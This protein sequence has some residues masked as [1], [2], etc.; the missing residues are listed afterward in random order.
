MC[1]K[2]NV[3][4]NP[5]TNETVNLNRDTPNALIVGA[6]GAGKSVLLRNLIHG[7]VTE[8]SPE[9]L[10]I[11][12]VDCR[13]GGF[14]EFA[15]GEGNCIVPHVSYLFSSKCSHVM[16]SALFMFE[17]ELR[18][19][20]QVLKDASVGTIDEYNAEFSESSGPMPELVLI[21]D[22]VGMALPEYMQPEME[23]FLSYV[24]QVQRTVGAHIIFCNQGPCKCNWATIMNMCDNRIVLRTTAKVSS[25][26][27]G[28]V[29]ASELKDKFGY[30][31]T[32][33]ER[34]EMPFSTTLWKVPNM[35]IEDI[36]VECD[37]MQYPFTRQAI[38]YV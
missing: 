15:D 22:E 32:N 38:M 12:M 24:A 27:L 4:Q 35:V 29:V 6:S 33:T 14:S 34:G 10:D 18:R 37:R 16:W 1:I 19:R 36:K 7:M 25:E 21:I 13:G 2:L 30:V 9:E 3:G 31:Y 20:A 26:V 11:M 23:K 28:S 8:F 5:R 17:A